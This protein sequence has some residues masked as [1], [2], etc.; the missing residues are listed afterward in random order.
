M[1]QWK[2]ISIAKLTMT[3]FK[4]F[5]GKHEIDLLTKP[6]LDKNLILIGGDNGRGKT[7]IHEAINYVLYEDGDLPNIHTRPNY[8]KAV[9]DRL[10]RRALDEGQPD[11][12]VSIDLIV[13]SGDAARHLFIERRWDVNVDSRS[14]K[15]PILI[16]EENGRPIDW[17]EDNPSAYQDF[18]RH[19]IPPRIAPF[20]L[21]DGERIQEFAEVEKEGRRMIEAIEDILHITVYKT[22]RDD[23]KKHVIDYID[24]NEVKRK[25]TKDYY[26]ILEDAE[27]IESELDEKKN[28]LVEVKRE[29]EDLNREQRVIEDELRRIASPHAS[30]RDELILEKQKIEQ[31]LENIKQDMEDS[32]RALPILLSGKICH[33]LYSNLKDENS[34]ILLT[35]NKINYLNNQ[36]YLIKE[37]VFQSPDPPPQLTYLL[38]Y[39]KRPFIQIDF[40]MWLKKYLD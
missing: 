10:N 34:N 37:K 8:L 20:F 30:K 23:I 7:S 29:L 24:K 31:D 40:L 15:Q 25:E 38:Q 19:V 21:F 18:L 35:P 22:L 4:R 2:H 16:I 6:E 17:I 39:N 1:S 36:F 12:S 9:S 33:D 13:S 3:N 5:Y 26:K 28:E 27:R 14:V 11:Y 32:F